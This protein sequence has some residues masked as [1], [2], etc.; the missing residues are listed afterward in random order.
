MSWLK[1]QE[2]VLAPTDKTRNGT[3]V[4]LQED[5]Q[6]LIEIKQIK[7]GDER[8]SCF[9]HSTSILKTSSSDTTRK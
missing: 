8:R 9:H 6:L 7:N 4:T 5:L 3:L 2:T 1:F